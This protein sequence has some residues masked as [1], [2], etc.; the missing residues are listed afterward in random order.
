[1]LNDGYLSA[2]TGGNGLFLL[3]FSRDLS[4]KIDN[5]Q[6][7]IG[8][9]LDRSPHVIWVYNTKQAKKLSE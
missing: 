8:E 5:R 4:P 2:H 1:M 3:W 7:D 9:V 6:R